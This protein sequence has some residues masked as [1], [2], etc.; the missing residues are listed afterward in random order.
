[1]TEPERYVYKIDH[2]DYLRGYRDGINA[3]LENYAKMQAEAGLQEQALDEIRKKF[4]DDDRSSWGIKAIRV[5][6]S[7]WTGKGINI[8]ILDTGLYKDHIDLKGRKIT[9][10]KF[11]DSGSS[12]DADGHGSHCTGIACGFKDEAG[13]RYGVAY[14]SS[15]FSGKVLSDQG[16]G[17]DGGILAGIEWAMKKKCRVISMSLGAACDVGEPYSKT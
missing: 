17:T 11:V 9:I 12:G 1:M 13:K 16:E 15:I 14:R 10:K 3:L 2:H 6:E 8:A 5:P 4:L 7:S